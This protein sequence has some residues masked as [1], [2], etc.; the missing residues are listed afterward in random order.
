MRR[1]GVGGVSIPALMKEAGLTHGGFYAHFESRDELVA[2]AIELAA[3]ETKARVF[4]DDAAG[5]APAL[6]AYLSMEHAAHPEYGCVVAALGAEAPR[7]S[8]TVK[9]SFRYAARGLLR[10]VER[11]LHP[12]SQD[13]LHDD[14]LR[15]ARPDGGRGGAGPHGRGQGAGEAPARQ[16]P[17]ALTAGP[18]VRSRDRLLDE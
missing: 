16:R 6:D 4:G 15:L 9:E 2:A 7:Q 5:V 10:L 11:R 13:T 18:S 3:E 1:L 14:T 12:R 17:E 8:A